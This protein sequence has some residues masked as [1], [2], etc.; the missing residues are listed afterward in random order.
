MLWKNSRLQKSKV[1]IIKTHTSL[2]N[3]DKGWIILSL[4]VFM[5]CCAANKQIDFTWNGF[6][7]ALVSQMTVHLIFVEQASTCMHFTHLCGDTNILEFVRLVE[8][9]AF[10]CDIA[11]FAKMY[12]CCPT[13]LY[14]WIYWNVIWVRLLLYTAGSIRYIFEIAY[15][16]Y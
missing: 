8:T 7:L 15:L 2:G 12:F 13:N 6:I 16:C 4:T 9:I 11:I 1:C 10:D 5:T 3:K 14:I